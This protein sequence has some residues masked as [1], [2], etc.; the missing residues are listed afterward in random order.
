MAAPLLQGFIPGRCLHRLTSSVRF[1]V[2]RRRRAALSAAQA[3]VALE[4]LRET[5]AVPGASRLYWP[6]GSSVTKRFVRHWGLTRIGDLRGEGRERALAPLSSTAIV[7][8]IPPPILP[9]HG[10]NVRRAYCM[11]HN[12]NCGSS[13]MTGR[14]RVAANRTSEIPRQLAQT[15]RGGDRPKCPEF[16]HL[17]APGEAGCRSV[18]R[19]VGTVTGSVGPWKRLGRE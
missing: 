18:P 13:P 10:L 12:A 14:Q 1:V 8:C 16:R 9:G 7:A 4:N 19:P 5:C 2:G 11:R 3:H 6:A 17:G 15:I